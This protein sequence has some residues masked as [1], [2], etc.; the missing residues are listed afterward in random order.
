MAM[1]EITSYSEG[2]PCWVD[3]AVPDVES[4]K[5]FYTPLF[6]WDYIDT[7]PEG[8][9]YLLATLRGSQVAGIGPI[10]NPDQ[11]VSWTTYLWSDDADATAKLITDAGGALLMEPFE[12]MDQ[13]RM[14]IAADPA[15]AVFGLWQGKA[16]R[17]SG[18]ANEH[19]SFTWNELTTPDTA[20]AR[21]FYSTVFGYAYEPVEGM[22]YHVFQVGGR[23]VGG[24]M[25]PME[26]MPE[27]PPHWSVYFEVDDTDAAVAAVRDNGGELIVGPQDTP[28]GRMAVVRDNGG[29]TFD[30]IHGQG[31]GQTSAP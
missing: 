13:G 8:G 25:G 29:A 10:Q 15:G 6:G 16:H 19:G 14:A 9:G 5:Q 31:S 27:L 1:V 7:G 3:L 30:L 22:D 4:A 26:G 18:L 2:V 24:F 23:G 28:Y 12:V 17:G 11:P 20:A 21:E